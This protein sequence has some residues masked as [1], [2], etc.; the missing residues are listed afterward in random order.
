MIRTYCLH[1]PVYKQ[2]DD[3][4]H[5]LAN[6]NDNSVEALEAL[7]AAYEHAS[8]NCKQLASY[9]AKFPDSGIEVDGDSNTIEVTGPTELLEP[10]AWDTDETIP[11]DVENRILTYS[12][13]L[14]NEDYDDLY[15]QLDYVEECPGCEHCE[16]ELYEEPLTITITVG[17]GLAK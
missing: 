1:L 6:A 9:L 3:L 13:E 8:D 16:P 11:T 17:R 15:D 12:S 10:I 4:A 2:G 14:E 5:C 7:A